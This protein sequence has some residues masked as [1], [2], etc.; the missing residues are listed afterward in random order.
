MKRFKF[1]PVVALAVTAFLSQASAKEPPRSLPIAA[2][3]QA[4][5]LDDCPKDNVVIVQL[6][7]WNEVPVSSHASCISLKTHDAIVRRLRR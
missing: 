7:A 3:P 1:R 5:H 6:S 4:S 2:A